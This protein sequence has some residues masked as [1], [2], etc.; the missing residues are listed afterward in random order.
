MSARFF[1]HPGEYIVDTTIFL[2]MMATTASALALLTISGNAPE[3]SACR[4]RLCDLH[5]FQFGKNRSI[6]QD[7]RRADRAFMLGVSCRPRLTG[8]TVL[9]ANT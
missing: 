3:V 1:N 4:F 9:D 7:N 8:H 5:A 2:L 6:N